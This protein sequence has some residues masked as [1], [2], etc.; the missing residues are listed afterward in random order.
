MGENQSIYGDRENL[1]NVNSAIEMMGW[2][3][4]S[5]SSIDAILA[6]SGSRNGNGNVKRNAFGGST[7]SGG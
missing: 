5:P 1:Y 4:C 7:E 6:G 2:D 3:E